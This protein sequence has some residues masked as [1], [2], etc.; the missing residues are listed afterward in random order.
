MPTLRTATLPDDAAAIA[1]VQVASW[2]TTYRGIVADETLDALSEDIKRQRLETQQASA[3][4]RIVLALA[5]E[6]TASSEVIGFIGGGPARSP[7]GTYAT[8]QAEIY[9]LYLLEQQQRRGTGRAL[10][11]ALAQQLHAQGYP[12]L[13][14]WVLTANP[15]VLFYQHLGAVELTQSTVT[16]GNQVLPELALGWSNIEHLF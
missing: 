7:E 14:V 13:M 9:A 5:S 11:R 4:T 12:N 6:T 8:Y 16:I 10:I 2:K 3:T 15:A 1:H